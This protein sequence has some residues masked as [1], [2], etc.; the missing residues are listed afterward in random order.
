M[1]NQIEP[2]VRPIRC[3]REGKSLVISLPKLVIEGLALKP[4]DFVWIG[5]REGEFVGRK[6]RLGA[7]GARMEVD[8]EKQ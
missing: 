8:R 2:N 7:I 4:G 3:R 1:N 5:L 6:I